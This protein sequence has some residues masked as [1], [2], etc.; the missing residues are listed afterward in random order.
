VM[1]ML[2]HDRKKEAGPPT[3]PAPVIGWRRPSLATNYS[4]RFLLLKLCAVLLVLVLVSPAFSRPARVQKVRGKRT[5]WELTNGL[6]LA[7]EVVRVVL[8][9]FH[10]DVEAERSKVLQRR[11]DCSVIVAHHFHV[12]DVV[13]RLKTTSH[14]R[15]HIHTLNT[16]AP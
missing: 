6:V 4:R 15:M 3:V 9:A 12:R 13:A 5:I 11:S 16:C 14:T 8:V 1:Q 2:V 7:H 10:E